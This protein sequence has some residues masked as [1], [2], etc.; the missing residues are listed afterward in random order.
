MS[1]AITVWSVGNISTLRRQSP[2]EWP[3]VLPALEA[4]AT[5]IGEGTLS[6]V[7]PDFLFGHSLDFYHRR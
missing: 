3:S 7:V 1:V 2:H 6:L 5:A 4:D